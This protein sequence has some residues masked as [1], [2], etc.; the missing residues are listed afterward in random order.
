[1][2]ELLLSEETLYG[3]HGNHIERFNKPKSEQEKIKILSK[4]GD[5]VKFVESLDQ[6]SIE[7]RTEKME[8]EALL[9][10][11]NKMVKRG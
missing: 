3:S 11:Q 8:L 4:R 6:N 5:I 9:L 1:M 7:Y 2:L 10:Q